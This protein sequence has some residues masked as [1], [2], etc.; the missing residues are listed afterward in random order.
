MSQYLGK[1]WYPQKLVTGPEMESEDNKAQISLCVDAVCSG[2]SLHTGSLDS[3][4]YTKRKG[5]FEQV[6]N[7]DSSHSCTKFQPGICSPLI[8]TIVS[9][10]FVSRQRRPCSDCVDVHTDLGLRCLHMPENTILHSS[11]AVP[12]R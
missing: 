7:A 9:I 12:C 11:L 3:I 1:I 5:V 10:D 4:G 6:Q 2:S 8:H